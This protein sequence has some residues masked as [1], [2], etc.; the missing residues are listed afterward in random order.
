MTCLD[1]KIAD[2]KGYEY[3]RKMIGGGLG[4]DAPPITSEAKPSKRSSISGM[5]GLGTTSTNKDDKN[6]SEAKA[7]RMC[8]C[9]ILSKVLT[10]YLCVL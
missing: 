8:V 3:M 1:G 7:V 10:L 6:T 9:V 2:R 5:L 4:G